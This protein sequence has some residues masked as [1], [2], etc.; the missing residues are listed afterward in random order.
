MGA[1][2]GFTANA[3]NA[4][5][6]D[7]T[8]AGGYRINMPVGIFSGAGFLALETISLIF[9]IDD[10]TTDTDGSATVSTRRYRPLG[11]R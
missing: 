11:S 10:T 5:L 6:I 2:M 3:A 9:R 1:L 8:I 4:A 7:V